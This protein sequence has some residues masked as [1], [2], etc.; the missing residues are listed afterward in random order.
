MVRTL[1][2][3]P[4]EQIYDPTCGSGGLLIK[5]QLVLKEKAKGAVEYPLK[6]FGQENN[7]V[8]Y[9]MAKM[10]MIIHDDG[11]TNVISTDSLEDFN[12][13]QNIKQDFKAGEFDLLL[14]NPPFG[15]T[16]KSSEKDY[17]WMPASP[18]CRGTWR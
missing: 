4:G 14:T 18:L 12:H 9:A 6:L 8:T 7:P 16:V 1:K 11:H 3:D 17:L 10:N 15:A 13:I 5:A 2:P